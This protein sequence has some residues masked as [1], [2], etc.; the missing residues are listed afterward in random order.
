MGFRLLD[1]MRQP[2]NGIR[3][4]AVYQIAKT[5]CVAEPHTLPMQATLAKKRTLIKEMNNEK[6]KYLER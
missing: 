2:E 3:F 1:G 6:I 5:S 4:Q